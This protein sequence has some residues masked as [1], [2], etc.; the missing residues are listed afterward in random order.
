MAGREVGGN[1]RPENVGIQ[2]LSEGSR[3]AESPGH[4][5]SLGRGQGPLNER[6]GGL[7]VYSVVFLSRGILKR[8][9]VLELHG[10]D[11]AGTQDTQNAP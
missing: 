8:G 1:E 3:A 10:D 4:E 11:T 2:F 6:Y 7:D 5:A 9:S